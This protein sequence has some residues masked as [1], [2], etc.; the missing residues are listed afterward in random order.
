MAISPPV[1]RTATRQIELRQICY[2]P[3]TLASVPDGMLA[4]DYQDNA[5]PDWREYWPIRQF[6]LN[7]VLAEDTLYGFFSPK[8]GYKT[9]LD[10]AK[11]HT[12]I[13]Q[14]HAH[15][16]AYFFSPFW[17]LSSFFVNIFEQGDFFHPGLTKASQL[18]VDSIGW[19]TNVKFHVTHSQNTVF[20]N[21]IVANKA[22]WL[23][24][25]ALSERLFFAA[26]H[27]DA[28]P[29]LQALL[30]DDTTYG[31]Q[32]L[33]LK[34]FLLERLAS[35]LLM[36]E[37]KLKA[38]GYDCFQLSPSITPLNQFFNEAVQ[39][40]ALKLA[41]DQSASPFNLHAFMNLRNQVF[42]QLH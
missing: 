15:H 22:F 23:K 31:E 12:F 40:N 42:Q 27:P 41:Y 9:G 17:D 29:V 35:L 14:D 28:D 10:S 2:S 18:F 5:R 37:A 33:P 34:V 36:N 25:L 32:R 38:K 19:S 3:Q 30:K 7:N 1:T 26:E 4:L 6:L 16:D 39:C 21:Y 11:V 24:W 13:S 20:C 8:F